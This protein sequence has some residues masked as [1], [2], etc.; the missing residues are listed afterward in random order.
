MARIGDKTVYP[1]EFFDGGKNNQYGVNIIEDNESPDCLNVESDA[2]GNVGTRNGSL[3]ATHSGSTGNLASGTWYGFTKLEVNT[4]LSMAVGWYNSSLV[5]ASASTFTSFDSGSLSFVTVP[6]A[7]G[8]FTAL[9]HVA[10]TYYDNKI[11]MCDG[12]T[13]YKYDGTYFTRMG[14]DT[15]SNVMSATT[16]S[17]AAAVLGSGVYKYKVAY[18]N[19]AGIEG[20]ASTTALVFTAHASNI[21]SLTGLPTAPVSYGVGKRFLYRTTVGGDLFYYLDEIADNTTTTY[22]DEIPDT[23]LIDQM[24]P[25]Q[26]YPPSFRLVVQHKDRIFAVDDANPAILK[27]SEV[28]RYEL[29]P[30]ENEEKLGD[31]AGR[32]K[33]LA[34]H[35]DAILAIKNDG[36]VWLLFL[37]DNDPVNFI[38]IKLNAPYG[39]SS[40][41]VVTYE[42][43][44][45][46]LGTVGNKPFGFV[47]LTGTQP[48]NEG[49]TTDE[50]TTLSRLISEKITP[51][52]EEIVPSLIDG[53]QGI[54]YRNRVFVTIP[55]NNLGT[56]IDKNNFIYQFDYERRTNPRQ[57]GAWFPFSDLYAAYF[58]V[59]K[60][61][62]LYVPSGERAIGNVFEL[63]VDGRAYDDTYTSAGVLTKSMA[64]NDYFFTKRYGCG[65]NIEQNHKDFRTAYVWHT[66]IDNF[67][68]VVNYRSDFDIG[69]GNQ[70]SI[71]LDPGG[72]IWGQFYWG[73]STWG[74]ATLE[75]ETDVDLGTLN[76][77]RIQFKFSNNN[78]AG[79]RWKVKRL[80]IEFTLRPR[81]RY[82]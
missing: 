80:G 43:S 52:V 46:Y 71:N 29:W 78:V 63:D 35:N 42:D 49:I 75:N 18:V 39:T 14:I 10:N 45:M 15:P 53:I 33:A 58:T 19:S 47:G 28:G 26:G 37:A 72:T 3:F 40:R 31:G 61:R 59:F 66:L 5:V 23:D 62:L 24:P 77:R 55:R 34:V 7:D 25:D 64:I 13:P 69:S 11:L 48:V 30:A 74:G 70:Q 51:D 50:G 79:A 21:V 22:K 1:V 65:K 44:A 81:R 73:L 16:A 27:F 17:T 4:G 57:I 36:S 2:L 6:S 76:G 38:P 82:L 56:S 12:G 54:V 9:T 67:D 8:V 68:L 60:D 41:F 32:I 20:D